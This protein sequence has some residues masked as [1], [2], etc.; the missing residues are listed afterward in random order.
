MLALAIVLLVFGLIVWLIL[1]PA[2]RVTPELRFAPI[3]KQRSL[4]A[5]AR[6]YQW[7]FVG[8]SSVSLGSLLLAIAMFMGLA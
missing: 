7:Y 4:F 3:W 5:S 6:S 8:V 2:M 1:R